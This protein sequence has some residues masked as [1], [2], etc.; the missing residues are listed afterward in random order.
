M[1][2]F[3]SNLVARALPVAPT[4]RPRLPFFYEGSSTGADS[5]PQEWTREASAPVAG[6]AD[7]ATTPAAAPVDSTR[8]PHPRSVTDATGWTSKSAETGDPSQGA[9]SLNPQ[10]SAKSVP[11]SMPVGN[12]RPLALDKANRASPVMVPDAPPPSAA[13]EA[14]SVPTLT[15]APTAR[16]RRPRPQVFPVRAA[17]AAAPES[18]PAMAAV[19]ATSQIPASAEPPATTVEVTIGRVEVRAVMTPARAE[20][21]AASTGQSLDTYLRRRSGASRS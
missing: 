18:D 9:E 6:Q 15:D 1:S 16:S 21:P 4:V 5:P 19:R 12:T 2:G 14:R 11:A 17:I 7:P 8:S 20:R 13:M 3:L 10:A